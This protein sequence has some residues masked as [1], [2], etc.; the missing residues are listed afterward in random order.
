MVVKEAGKCCN[1]E[2]MPLPQNGRDPCA[3]AMDNKDL[4]SP[5]DKNQLR[6]GSGTMGY[7]LC[8]FGDQYPCT[9][10]N[11]FPSSWGQDMQDCILQEESDHL[12]STTIR[13]PP[14]I[15]MATFPDG[16]TRK[17]EECAARADTFACMEDLK[18]G[19]SSW[20]RQTINEAQKGMWNDMNKMGCENLPP[21]P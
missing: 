15:G 5:A 16:P 6:N 11:N 14:C 8:L 9:V 17:D 13:C 20:Y 19:A 12:G 18:A 2:C 1:G 3:W 4:M 10:P 21:E 7:V